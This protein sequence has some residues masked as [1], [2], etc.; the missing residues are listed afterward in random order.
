MPA[1][2]LSQNS[3]SKERSV[4]S[5]WV[6]RYCRS[7]SVSRNTSSDGLLYWAAGVSTFTSKSSP[8]VLSRNLSRPDPLR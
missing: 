5:S 7:V 6:T 2:L 8:Q 4:A 3:F 1:R